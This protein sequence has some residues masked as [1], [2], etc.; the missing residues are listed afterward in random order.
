MVD[1]GLPFKGTVKGEA[2]HL[3]EMTPHHGSF[4]AIH[5]HGEQQ[6]FP[7]ALFTQGLD[8]GLFQVLLL[9]IKSM[10]KREDSVSK[11]KWTQHFE[12]QT[13]QHFMTIVEVF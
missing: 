10:Q 2:G 9:L 13:I 6:A 7:D 11:C 8:Q 1:H 12:F 4:A 3:G 5:E